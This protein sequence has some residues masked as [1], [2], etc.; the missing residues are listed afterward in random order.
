[1]RPYSR[2]RDG[3]TARPAQG[4]GGC[5]DAR[6]HATDQDSKKAEAPR[7]QLGQRWMGEDEGGLKQRYRVNGGERETSGGDVFVG[8]A[9]GWLGI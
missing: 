3:V 5:P 6:G 1:M 9:V 8:H 7:G 2:M 4:Q